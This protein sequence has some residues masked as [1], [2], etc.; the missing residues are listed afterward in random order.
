MSWVLGR[1]G[2]DLKVSRTFYIA[3]TQAVLLFGAETWVLM[4]RMEK[5]LD[6]LQSRV[7]RK[8]VGRQPRGKKDRMWEYPPMAE[9]LREAGMVGIR[10]SITRRQNMF[11]Q[12]I[13]T[14]PILDL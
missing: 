9:A 4:S 2:A 3:F 14:R 5:V 6:S 13:A 7:A 10:T 12:Y 11:A 1:E 8:R